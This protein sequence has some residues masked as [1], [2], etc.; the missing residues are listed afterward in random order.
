MKGDYHNLHYFGFASGLELDYYYL[1]CTPVGEDRFNSDFIVDIAN[2]EAA[3]TQMI[4]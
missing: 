2:L 3:I 4:L 1:L